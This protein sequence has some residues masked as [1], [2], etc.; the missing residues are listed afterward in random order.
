MLNPD[1]YPQGCTHLPEPPATGCPVG[2]VVARYACVASD[3]LVRH[4]D[5][6]SSWTSS[7]AWIKFVLPTAAVVGLAAF[8]AGRARRKGR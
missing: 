7:P 2:C 8:F 6:I 4:C 1:E 5:N 3:D